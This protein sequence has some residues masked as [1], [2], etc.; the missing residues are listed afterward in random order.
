MNTARFRIAGNDSNAQ[1]STYADETND[2]GSIVNVAWTY[3]DGGRQAWGCVLGSFFLMFP[4]FGF[5]V[6]LGTVQDYIATHQL[7]DYSLSD[8]GW[9]SAILVFLTLFLGVQVGPLFD[10]YGPRYLLILGTSGSF[11]SYILLAQCTR[12]W[13]F[14]LCLSILGGVSSAIVTTVAIAV[15]SHWFH[16]RRALASGICMGGSSAGGAIIPLLLRYTFPNYG[17]AW[18]MRIIAFI[19]AACYLAGTIL[20]RGRLPLVRSTAA[21][22]AVVDVRAFASARL[23]FLALAVFSF[24]FIIF[25]CAALLPTYIRY[26]SSTGSSESELP[27]DMQFYVLTVLNSMSF[28]GRTIPGFF[29]DKMGCFNVLL[30]LVITTLVTMGA[31]WV[32]VGSHSSASVL[33]VIVA[34]FGFGSG[35]WISLA[36]VCAGQLCRTDE[37]GRFYGTIYMIAAFGVL[38]TVPIGGELLQ[39]ATPQILIG[40]YAGILV[41]GLLGVMTSRWAILDWKWKWKVKV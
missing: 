22:R 24:E 35:G 36:P 30:L 7:S 13:Q 18:S 32:P 9:I 17:W 23:S 14:V 4:S 11:L 20:V 25:G 27:S 39:Y 6:A 1:D 19:S 3:P 31:I 34:L 12:Y 16:R 15:L 41:L 5:E 40:F 8:V 21:P 29:A 33:Y 26:S 28:L 10:R 37:Y 2:N 38:L